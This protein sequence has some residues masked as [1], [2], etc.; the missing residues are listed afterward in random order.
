MSEWLPSDTALLAVINKLSHDDLLN[1]WSLLSPEEP[2]PI[3]DPVQKIEHKFKWLFYSTIRREALST[4]KNA[5]TAIKN[6]RSEQKVEY[7]N[8][9]RETPIPTY[10]GLLREACK[11]LKCFIN[12]QSEETSEI[13]FVE[14]LCVMALDNMKPEDRHRC[15]TTQF[16]LEALRREVKIKGADTT[17]P[18]ATMGLLASHKP[19]AL[20]FI[21]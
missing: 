10:T 11:E 9:D 5:W 12:N 20:E 16:D 1:V 21:Y 15:L 19:L 4:A 17:G 3:E 18:A 7:T 8:A 2:F 14:K 6:F 13:Y